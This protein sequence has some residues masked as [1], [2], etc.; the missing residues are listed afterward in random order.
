MQGTLYLCATPIG[1]LED[2]T[3]RCLRILKEADVIAAEDTRRTLGLLTH[4]DIRKPVMSCH[5][6]NET[7]ASKKILSLL[8]DGK[9]VALVTDA[10]MPLIS[11][12]GA[13]AAK[14]AV[15]AGFSVTVVPGANAALTALSLSC[16]DGE[17]FAFEG[18][19]PAKAKERR[20]RLGA[21][22][23]ETRTLI[24]Y[25]APHRVAATLSELYAAFGERDAA[26][27]RELTKLHEEVLRI[28]LSKAAH[29]Y[30]EASPRGEYV[31]VV[32]GAEA[33]AAPEATDEELIK[34]LEALISNGM[35]R[36]DAA[37]EAAKR[38]NVSKNRAYGLIK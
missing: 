11:D 3:L 35:S 28:K 37:A 25:E 20:E 4:F 36:R 14:E 15:A 2:I 18:F 22:A 21:I 23:G 6:H 13:I 5:E 16:I 34:A 38:F 8:S 24:F 12:P 17:R 30:D 10:G 32:S 33:A 1:N 31:I 29:I 26:I 9:N 19:L 27:A 7:E